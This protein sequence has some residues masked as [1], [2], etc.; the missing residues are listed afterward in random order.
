MEVDESG[1]NIQFRLNEENVDERLREYDIEGASLADLGLVSGVAGTVA[2]IGRFIDDPVSREA[3]P[4]DLLIQELNKRK[5]R[6]EKKYQSRVDN[7]VSAT[8]NLD[9]T[10]RQEALG[11]ILDQLASEE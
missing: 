10:T 1:E 2:D 4:R 8:Q 7:L 9:V 5:R 3:P 6:I 11:R